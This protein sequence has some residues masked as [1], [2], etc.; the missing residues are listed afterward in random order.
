MF[1]ALRVRGTNAAVPVRLRQ[2]RLL[3]ARH[4]RRRLQS[5]GPDVLAAVPAVLL[6]SIGLRCADLIMLGIGL[7]RLFA[8]LADR[9]R[10]GWKAS[11]GP[12]MQTP[13]HMLLW[14]LV[15]AAGFGS[16]TGAVFLMPAVTAFVGELF[17]R[18]DRR[19]GRAHAL[20]GR[21]AGHAGAARPRPDR[22]HQDRAA[23]A[24]WSISAPCRFCCSPGLAW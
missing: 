24:R 17:R 10:P 15:I 19:T 6:E 22:G 8:W 14:M 16:S 23:R 1:R 21:S 11:T 9:A 4:V 20:S 2:R 5:P 18:R 13:L 3:A 12:G 7:H